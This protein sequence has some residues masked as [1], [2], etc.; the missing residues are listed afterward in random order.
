MPVYQFEAMNQAGQ[1]QKGTI[2]ASNSEDAI[3]RIKAKGYFPTSVR[4]KKTKA[5]KGG[6]GG[7]GGAAPKKGKKKGMEITI[8]FG[9]VKKK[10]ITQFSRQMSTLQDAG[11]PILRSL[12]ILAEQ[13]KPGQFKNIVEEISLDVEGGSALSEAM[14]KH[15]KA[16]DRLYSKM[17]AAGEVGGVLDLI[18][19][20]LADFME[21][22]EALRK[23]II[24]AMIYPVA[25][26]MI[27]LLI[28]TFI[29]IKVIPKF[30]AIFED[31]DAP[32][33]G[34]T[35][36]LIKMSNWVAGTMDGQWHAAMKE[37]AGTPGPMPAGYAVMFGTPDPPVLHHEGRPPQQGRSRRDRPRE[38]EGA[39]VRS[40]GQGQ[41]DREVHPN[42]GHAHRRRCADPRSHH[43]HP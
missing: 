22:A 5:K 28:V 24:S 1:P 19:Q 18:M 2:D 11:L 43:H 20:R 34:A 31:F 32:L 35:I 36:F 33:P 17:I 40:A 4:E 7:G 41:L 13:Q 8:S 6:G 38:D 12:Q 9:G 15:P 23:R 39:G 21:K 30:E 42:A 29:M 14:A 26:V 27:A 10:T 3:Q 37:P 16:F 25:V